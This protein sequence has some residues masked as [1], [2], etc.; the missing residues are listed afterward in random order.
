MQSEIS[1][2]VSGSTRKDFY[3]RLAGTPAEELPTG[4]GTAVISHEDQTGTE[5][6]SGLHLR[7]RA[8]TLCLSFRLL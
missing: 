7:Y 3:E 8:H 6:R 2:F 4:F 1:R 5:T